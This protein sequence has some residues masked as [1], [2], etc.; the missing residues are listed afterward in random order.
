MTKSS[1]I[2]KL[3]IVTGCE[4]FHPYIIKYS[5]FLNKCFELYIFLLQ[6]IVKQHQ[7]FIF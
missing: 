6:A 4:L 1:F 2:V 5:K 3:H 7:K